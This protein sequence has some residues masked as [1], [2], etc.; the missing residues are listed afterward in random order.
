MPIGINSYGFA[1]SF[2]ARKAKRA[3]A[4]FVTKL[5]PDD[6]IWLISA[7]RELLSFIPPNKLAELRSSVSVYKDFIMIFTDEEIYQWFP[8]ETKKF[9][10]KLPEGKDWLTKQIA[11]LRKEL[12]E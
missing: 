7:Q 8:E 3:L 2:V 11:L 9:V 1:R 5:K 12:L 6:I 4:G 10:E